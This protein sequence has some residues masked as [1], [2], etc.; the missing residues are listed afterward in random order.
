MIYQLPSFSLLLTL[1]LSFPLL[2]LFCTTSPYLL[3]TACT[4]FSLHYI[5][6]KQDPWF[7][8]GGNVASGV[9]QGDASQTEA[10]QKAASVAVGLSTFSAPGG[11]E[12]K[13]GAEEGLA[14]AA[15][16]LN[17]NRTEWSH[18]GAT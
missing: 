8:E 6:V 4:S 17:R 1:F 9:V 7:L 10:L 13:D 2:C 3:F 11:A 14:A 5:Q 12:G 16:A 15:E 18:R